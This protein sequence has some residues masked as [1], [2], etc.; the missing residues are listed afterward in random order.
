MT[1][2]ALSS[3]HSAKQFYQVS[4]LSHSHYDVFTITV[5]EPGEDEAQTEISL[6]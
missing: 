4:N 6:G 2:G 5:C 3:F 1:L